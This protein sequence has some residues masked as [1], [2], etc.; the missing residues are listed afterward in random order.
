MCVLQIPSDV[1]CLLWVAMEGKHLDAVRSAVAHIIAE[2]YPMS[3]LLDQLQDDVLYRSSLTDIDKALIC[4]QIAQVYPYFTLSEWPMFS[5]LCSIASQ[6]DHSLSDG[7]SELLQLNKIANFIT[8]RLGR[9]Q[10][11]I[12]SN[13]SSP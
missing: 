7:S 5:H 13:Q 2:G 9:L 12:D 4:Q 3:S 10:L 8:R 6:A 1:M 11:D